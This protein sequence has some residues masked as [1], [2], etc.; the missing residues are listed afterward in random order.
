MKTATALILAAAALV[1]GACGGTEG[2]GATPGAAD[3]EKARK[4]QLA[5]ARCMRE[6]GIDMPDPAAGEGG[7]VQFRRPGGDGATPP[8]RETV[9]RAH[10]AC[11]KHTK[12]IRPPELSPEQARE[13]KQAALRH[14]KCMRDQG[15]DFPDPKFGDAGEV[16][17]HIDKRSGIDPA[18]PAFQR[19]QK[20]CAKEMPGGP[21]RAGGAGEAP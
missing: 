13:M 14:A 12:G 7:V 17:V 3:R 19:A 11:A 4:A 2:D 16:A 9:E 5:F 20:A 10:E 6:N 18:S 21:V 1:A 15:I 8:P